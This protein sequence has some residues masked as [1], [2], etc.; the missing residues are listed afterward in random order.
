MPYDN[1][2]NIFSAH[3][4]EAWGYVDSLDPEDIFVNH[5]ISVAKMSIYDIIMSLLIIICSIT[6]E[7]CNG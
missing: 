4:N 6:R 1:R 7:V 2:G 5:R 3:Y